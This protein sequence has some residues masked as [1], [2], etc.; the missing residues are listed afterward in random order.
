MK[1]FILIGSLLCML[2]VS[3]VVPIESPAALTYTRVKVEAVDAASQSLTFKTAE[4]EVWTL[5]ALSADLLSGLH[6]GD[7]CSLEIDLDNRVTKIIKIDST[8]P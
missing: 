4:G 2:A 3:L 1:P 6:K 7:T 5:A 8:S